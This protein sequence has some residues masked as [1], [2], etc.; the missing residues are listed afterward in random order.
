[1]MKRILT[2]G[3]VLAAICVVTWV[4]LQPQANALSNPASKVKAFRVV[5]DTTSGGVALTSAAVTHYNTVRCMN[6]SATK[7]WIGGDDVNITDKGYPICTSSDCIDAAISID[8]RGAPRCLSAGSVN[9]TCIGA[10]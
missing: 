8:V 10:R 3:S 5:C 7:V 1:M 9:L 4:A 6:P 2:A